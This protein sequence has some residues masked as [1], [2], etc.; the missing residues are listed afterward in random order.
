MSNQAKTVLMRL[1]SDIKY[2]L[3][4]ILSKMKE[5]FEDTKRLIRIRRKTA[6]WTKE[7]RTK[8]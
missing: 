5:V 6:Q 8:G 2:T 1:F 7:K 4:Y 3:R